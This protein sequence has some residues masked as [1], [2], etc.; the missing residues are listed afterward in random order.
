MPAGIAHAEYPPLALLRGGAW[1]LSPAIKRLA[2]GCLALL[3]TIT[4]ATLAGAAI[5][6]ITS[7]S[8]ASGPVGAVVTN[9]PAQVSSVESR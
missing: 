5:P 4:P 1:R 6:T 7:F 8:P 3:L 9:L 2:A